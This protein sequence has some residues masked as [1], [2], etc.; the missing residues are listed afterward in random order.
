[1]GCAARVDDGALTI[2]QGLVEGK[3]CQVIAEVDQGRGESVTRGAIDG[4][5][6]PL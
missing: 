1:M 2:R 3:T 4:E 6:V 5:A